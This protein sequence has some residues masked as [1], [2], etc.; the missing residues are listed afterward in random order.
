MK[1]K[2]P[3]SL[4]TFPK[5]LAVCLAPFLA[6]ST[7]QATI[8]TANDSNGT[9]VWTLPSGNLLTSPSPSTV[10]SHEGSD[11]NWSRVIDGSLGDTGGTPGT[12]CTPN[13]NDVVT[14]PLDLTGHPGGRDI[15][16]FDSYCTWGNS[17]R[18]NQNYTL[19]YST[20]AD[21]TTFITITGVNNNTGGDR[22][23]H[24]QITNDSGP[25]ATG[26]HSVRVIFGG[27]NGGQ[28][29]GY[30]GYREFIVR[31]TPVI[32]VATEITSNNA[33]F[34]PAGPNLLAGVTP[35]ETPATHESSSGTWATTIDGSLGDFNSPTSSVTPNN[36][37]TVTFPLDLIAQPGGYNITSFD[38]FAAWGSNGR[39]DQHYTLSYSTV[40][41]P[42]TFIPI[43]DVAAHTEFNIS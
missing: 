19:Q 27:F 36:G 21:P 28:E 34:L 40:S 3:A 24:T 31:D 43:T 22:S 15:T 5:T 13:N 33:F 14:F 12:S 11:V 17:G 25:L 38:S 10:A 2:K 39:D 35:E 30:V 20:V 7:S 23:T 37:N 8:V 18:D 6:C 41:A 1:P 29:N 32:S 42:S 4:R 9:G 16:S 26:V